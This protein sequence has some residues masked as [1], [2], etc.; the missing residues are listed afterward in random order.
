MR[1]IF[2][3]H[4]CMTNIKKYKNKNCLGQYHA[5]HLNNKINCINNNNQFK[6]EYTITN[7]NT[8]KNIQYNECQLNNYTDS[9]KLW[10]KCIDCNYDFYLLMSFVLFK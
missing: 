6:N 5:P 1:R 8:C 3:E 7:K 2:Q 9:D 10:I 4:Y